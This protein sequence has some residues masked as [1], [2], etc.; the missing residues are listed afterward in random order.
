MVT[1]VCNVTIKKKKNNMQ[2]MEAND[3]IYHIYYLF[4]I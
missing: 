4:G 1:V 3:V 2:T